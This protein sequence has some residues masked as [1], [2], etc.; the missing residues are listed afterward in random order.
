MISAAFLLLMQPS[1]HEMPYINQDN[2]QRCKAASATLHQFIGNYHSFVTN[3]EKDNGGTLD[4]ELAVAYRG[5][6][7]N[8]AQPYFER[9]RELANLGQIGNG[10]ECE[11]LAAEA[12]HAVVN[13]VVGPI[14]GQYYN[15]HPD[16]NGVWRREQ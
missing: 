6:A 1:Y 5:M 15:Y 7:D 9:I 11:S 2:I 16:E 13:E 3:H 10:A 4:T 8:V 14:F 12:E